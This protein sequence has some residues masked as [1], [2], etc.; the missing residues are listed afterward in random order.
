MEF[1][2]CLSVSPRSLGLSHCRRTMSCDIDM[3]YASMCFV[4]QAH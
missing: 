3:L 1:S 2:H 4:V